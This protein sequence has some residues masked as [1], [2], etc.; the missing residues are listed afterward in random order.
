MKTRILVID[1]DERITDLLR[2]GLSYEGY[3][4]DVAHDG[5]QGLDLARE[6]P[7]DLVILDIMMPGRSTGQGLLLLRCRLQ[8]DLCPKPG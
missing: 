8:E 2:R 3:V 1:D 7:P 6:R 5:K 4:V